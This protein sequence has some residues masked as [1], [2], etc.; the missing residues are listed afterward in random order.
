MFVVLWLYSSKPRALGAVTGLFALIYALGRIGVEF[1]REP[2]AHIGFIAWGW[3]TQGATAEFAVA[4]CRR[5]AV[6]SFAHPLGC[7]MKTYLELLSDVLNHGTAKGDRTG[8]GTR[9]LFWA[10]DAL[11][12]C[13]RLSIDNDQAS[14]FQVG[15]A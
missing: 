3:L 12:S 13:S 5:V 6:I 1:L 4:A 8:T 2:D 11:R 14:A 10:A 9:S 7:A 15:G